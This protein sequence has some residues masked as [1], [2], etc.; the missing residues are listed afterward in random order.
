MKI[1]NGFVS[2]SSSSSFIVA[3]SKVPKTVEEMESVLFNDADPKEFDCYG[4]NKFT[5]TE[6]ATKVFNDL[7]SKN[8]EVLNKRKALTVITEGSF[9]GQPAWNEF[10]KESNKLYNDYYRASGKS[11]VDDDADPIAKK[12]FTK[13]Q[14]AEYKL[15]SVTRKKHAL[16]LLNK[17]LDSNKGKKMFR[18]EYSD[19]DSSIGSVL[20][21]SGIINRLPALQISYH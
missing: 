18:L 4:D 13:V 1:R 9:E 10:S 16:I 3:L 2:N 8:V 17:F 15:E 12:L 19:N 11:I 6:L 20:E 21:H 7:T 5:K 14:N